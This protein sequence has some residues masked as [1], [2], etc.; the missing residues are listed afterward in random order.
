MLLEHLQ[1][2]EKV[3]FERIITRL[4]KETETIFGERDYTEDVRELNTEIEQVRGLIE[5]T[6]MELNEFK[7]DLLQD[8]E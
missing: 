2:L 7:T 8:T 1:S 4:Q 3:H 5:E 6:L